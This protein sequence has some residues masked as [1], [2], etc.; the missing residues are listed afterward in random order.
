M[1][2]GDLLRILGQILGAKLRTESRPVSPKSF[3]LTED[4][5]HYQHQLSKELWTIGEASDQEPAVVG[6]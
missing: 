6:D 3:G 1:A 5:Q 4:V 2:T